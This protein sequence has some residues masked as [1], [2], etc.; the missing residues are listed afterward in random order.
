MSRTRGRAE[1]FFSDRLR[2][3]PRNIH[4]AAAA[5]PRPVSRGYP[6]HLARA[7]RYAT[8]EN[9]FNLGNGDE[10]RR[11]T[12]V[13]G[14]PPSLSQ[15]LSREEAVVYRDAFLAERRE[16]GVAYNERAF[17]GVVIDE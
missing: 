11:T 6:R 5:P 10:V 14:P 9:R 17:E 3:S 8:S 13:T 7:P 16:I 15:C 2:P 12:V 1:I 4:V